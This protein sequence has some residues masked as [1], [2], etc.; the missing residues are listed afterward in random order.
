MAGISAGWISTR[1]RKAIRAAASPLP[2]A[3]PGSGRGAASGTGFD[4]ADFLLGYPDTSSIA[5]G[6]ADKYL[7]ASWA[8]AYFTDDWRVSTKLSLNLGLRWDFQA[9]VTE[10]YNRLVNLTAGPAW[11][12][13][14]PVCGTAPADGQSCTAGRPGGSAQL[15]GAAQLP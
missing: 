14:T 5:Y 11:T 10:L 9:P 6:N 4:Y 7:R 3:S 12:S 8:D 15:A 1:S 2:A 13:A